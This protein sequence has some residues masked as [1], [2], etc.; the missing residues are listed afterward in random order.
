MSE[1]DD[2]RRLQGLLRGTLGRPHEHH[3]SLGS[4]ND[5]ALAWLL[6]GAPHGAVV[7]ADEQRAGRGRR[8]RRWFSPA[9]ESLYASLVLRPGAP[10][11]PARFGALGLAV[12]VGLREGLPE[13]RAP[14]ELKWPND[15]LVEG[16]KLGGIL[17]EA[18]WVGEEPQVVVG[19]GI[20][21]HT[22]SFPAALEGHATSLALAG[23]PGAAAPGRARLLAW[24]LASLQGALESFFRDGFA[25]VKERYLPHCSML[26]QAIEVGDPEHPASARRGV[27]QRLD[28]DGALWVLPQGEG[29]PFRVD[30]ADVW[31]ARRG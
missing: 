15:L 26:G 23:R 20:N 5:R 25:A 30:A 1:D 17:C 8:T 3:A 12:A 14:V 7:T 24:L 13:L 19:F 4:T 2:L 22:R 18:R 16:R 28:E 29:E 27:A 11:H 10:P 6:A 9:G 31:L 21:V